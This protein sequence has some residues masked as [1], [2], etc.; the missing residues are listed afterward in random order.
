MVIIW[1]NSELIDLC[2]AQESP[3]NIQ[4]PV[5]GEDGIFKAQQDIFKRSRATIMVLIILWRF[6]R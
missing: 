3:L 2:S 5:V 4:Q 1:Y 6:G